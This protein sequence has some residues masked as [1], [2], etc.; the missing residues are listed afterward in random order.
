MI[1]NPELSVILVCYNHEK[2]IRQAVESILMQRLNCIYE[3]IVADDFS[4]DNTLQILQEYIEQYPTLIKI[5]PT[6][7]NLGITKNYQRA[8]KAANGNYI[9]I[10]EGDDYW[11]SPLKLQEQRDILDLHREY[12]L[13]AHQFILLL[14]EAA[15]NISNRF[16]L[17]RLHTEQELITLTAEGLINDNIIGNFSTCMY[18]KSI[19]EQIPDSLFEM[20]VYDWMYN[21]V[22]AQYGVV[23]YINKPMSVYR[24]H[25]NGTWSKKTV[26]AKCEMTINLIEQYNKFLNCRFSQEFEE[27]KNRT[28]LLAYS[29]R[30][31]VIPMLNSKM[32]QYVIKLCIP[33]IAFIVY[34]FLVPP[35][36]GKLYKYFKLKM[37]KSND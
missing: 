28:Q 4:S 34:D 24:Q 29:Q 35:I 23:A 26:R 7:K 1:E 20:E 27:I 19:V 36:V 11:T 33:K 15:D 6:E 8:L 9:A 14:E 30:S 21:I 13:C 32:W 5:L 22:A 16:I 18:R 31:S 25:K 17:N 3:I 37:D 2:Y 12:S 10:L